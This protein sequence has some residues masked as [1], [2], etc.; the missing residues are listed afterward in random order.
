VIVRIVITEVEELEVWSILR[1]FI[2]S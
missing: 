2:F 1:H